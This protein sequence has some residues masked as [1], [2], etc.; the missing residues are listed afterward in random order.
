MIF[1]A[2]QVVWGSFKISAFLA[3]G[4]ETQSSIASLLFPWEEVN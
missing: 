3:M 1:R 4:E 2:Y